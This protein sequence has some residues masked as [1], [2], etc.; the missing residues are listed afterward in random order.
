MGGTVRVRV[1]GG[2]LELLDKVDLP[3]G[4]EITV[5]IIEA[6]SRRDREA[7][8]RAAGAWKDTVDAETLIRNIY[9]DRLIATRPEPRL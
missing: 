2:V 6:P 1:R 7:F 8:R 3:E 4:E 9:T 5:T